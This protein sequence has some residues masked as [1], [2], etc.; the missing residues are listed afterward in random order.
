MLLPQDLQDTAYQPLRGKTEISKKEK[1]RPETSNSSVQQRETFVSS[2]NV[3]EA[4]SGSKISP[5]L[6]HPS[7]RRKELHV[8]CSHLHRGLE[9][10]FK[11]T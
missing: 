7:H 2:R 4:A 11:A 1:G 8:T 9:L 5:T 3:I 6:P 10:L